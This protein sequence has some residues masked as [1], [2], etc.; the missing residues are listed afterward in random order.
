MKF[1][2][3]ILSSLIL[4]AIVP[5]SCT[6]TQKI[7]PTEYKESYLSITHAS[8]FPGTIKLF[9]DGK[10]AKANDSIIQGSNTI[11]TSLTNPY[12][13]IEK[14]SRQISIRVDGHTS[15]V[16]LFTQFFEGG[17]SYSLFLLDTLQSGR[18]KYMFIPD[19]FRSPLPAGKIAFRFL[20]FSPN[21]PPLDLYIVKWKAKDTF[22]IAES[23]T[24]PYADFNPVYPDNE[25]AYIDP[26]DYWLEARQTGTSTIIL[27]GGVQIKDKSVLTFYTKGLQ[28]RT[29]YNRLNIGL[30][31][32]V[33]P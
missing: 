28:G 31:E 11:Y 3:T 4:I 1:L 7:I 29:G 30:V 20:N 10:P 13:P 18:I 6:K 14:G 27:K 19:H 23:R 22:V 26:G 25:F 2:S 9:V 21:T 12:I 24:Y 33:Q 16:V 5:V 15:P 8:R 17:K 32:Y